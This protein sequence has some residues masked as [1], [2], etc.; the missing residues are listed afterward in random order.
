MWIIALLLG[1]LAYVLVKLVCSKVATLAADADLIGVI[2]GIA[3]AL[4]YL[5]VIH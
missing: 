1:L 4:L 5:G 3:V 2:A